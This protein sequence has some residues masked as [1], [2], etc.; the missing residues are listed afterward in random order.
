MKTDGERGGHVPRL[1]F[2][3][4]AVL[5]VSVG[6]LGCAARK[7]APNLPE[8]VAPVAFHYTA[9]EIAMERIQGVVREVSRV[10]VDAGCIRI[11]DYVVQ[12]ESVD[13]IIPVSLW[14][15]VEGSLVGKRVEFTFPKST[16]VSLRDRRYAVFVSLI[17]QSDASAKAFT[18]VARD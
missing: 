16:M 14:P 10:Q 6:L 7:V 15:S 12:L 4:I 11:N 8:E 2:A 5:T 18:L 17:R 3:L 9:G 1:S 13:V